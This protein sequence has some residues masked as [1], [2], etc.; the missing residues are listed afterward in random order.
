MKHFSPLALL[1]LSVLSVSGQTM[2]QPAT[3]GE[4]LEKLEEPQVQRA[5]EILRE[6]HV[7]GGS[8]QEVDLQRA[9]LRGL[10][11]NLE[12]GAAFLGEDES[13]ATSAPFRS[14]VLDGR[15]GYVRLGSLQ[16]EHLAELDAALE[17]FL[18]RRV[19]GVVLDLR[20][21]PAS[22]NF[23][24]AAEVAGRFC[25][26]GRALFSLEGSAAGAR[27]FTGQGPRLFQGVLIVLIDENT[28]GAAEALA[29]TLRWHARALLVGMRSSGRA[30]E[31]ESFE[32]GGGHHLELAVAEVSIDGQSVYPRG[33][34]PDLEIAQDPRVREAVLAGAL[35]QGAAVFLYERERAQ[36]NEAALLAGSAPELETEEAG[37]A[38]I[39]RPL[40]RAVDL[41][42]AIRLFGRPQ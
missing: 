25:P 7:R 33:L 26:P 17:D 28:S 18:V 37:P 3:L 12:P 15:A 39:D 40:Q 14:E 23:T 34:R 9:T 22:Q 13:A 1:L 4:R 35:E 38:L 5:L 16:T 21:T 11:E 27:S 41:V 8:L 2:E 36:M 24:L 10:I 30:V 20:A 42:T 6:K 19:Q 32:L 31:L 29:A